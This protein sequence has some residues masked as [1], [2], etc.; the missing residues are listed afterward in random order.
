MNR[1]WSLTA[2]RQ[3]GNAC[4]HF[5][6]DVHRDFKDKFLDLLDGSS[7]HNSSLILLR[8]SGEVAQCGDGM[9]LHFFVV[10]EGEKLDKGIKETRINDRGFV[11]RVYGD[12]PHAGSRGKDKR[13]VG[14]SEKAQ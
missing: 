10:F 1:N 9:T 8:T 4:C 5:A 6:L 11:L 2:K 3:N 12:V 13:Q 14:R 7:L